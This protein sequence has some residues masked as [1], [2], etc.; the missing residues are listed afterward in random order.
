MVVSWR[1]SNDLASDSALEIL[2]D[3]ISKYGIPEIV[4]SDQ[5]DKFTSSFWVETLAKHQI[6]ISMTGKGRSNDNAYRASLGD[7]KI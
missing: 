7:L 6:K 3:A 5:E 2:D 1:L 4:N